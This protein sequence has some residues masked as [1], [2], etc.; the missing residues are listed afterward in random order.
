[1]ADLGQ[2]A[3]VTFW[4][5]EN[6]RRIQLT[7]G[8]ATVPTSICLIV[9]GSRQGKD[10]AALVITGV[11]LLL[12]GIALLVRR[13]ARTTIDRY[14]VQ[15]WSVFGRRSCQWSEVTDVS[16]HWEHASDAAPSR[17]VKIQLSSG[18]SFKLAV[19]VDTPDTVEHNPDFGTQLATI[20][21]YW[22]AARSSLSG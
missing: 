22:Q 13:S 10:S 4:K 2:L 15:T 19:P 7:G 21:S 3:P 11:L 16:E 14:G 12:F 5:S 18:R 6:Q 20:T 8:I 1:M 9:V 17:C